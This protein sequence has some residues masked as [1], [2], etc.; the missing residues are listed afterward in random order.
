M[1]V[2][3]VV[4]LQALVIVGVGLSS[5]AC[6]S[7]LSDTSMEPTNE[8][9]FFFFFFFF[10][11]FF[12]FFFFFDGVSARLVLLGG[13]RQQLLALERA[14]PSAFWSATHLRVDLLLEIDGTAEL[15]GEGRI[16]RGDALHAF[17][18]VAVTVGA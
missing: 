11:F 3:M 5:K 6:A 12:F 18:C 17:G 15:R 7:P 16:A 13:Q 1:Q 4:V 8:F 2:P 14:D 10:V 9:I